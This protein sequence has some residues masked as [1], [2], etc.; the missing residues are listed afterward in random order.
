MIT[1]N[2]LATGA[3]GM[4]T[5]F[6]NPQQGTEVLIIDYLIDW[7]SNNSPFDPPDPA[8]EQRITVLGTPP[9]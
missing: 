7:I 9:P 4:S 8:I 6:A 3:L 2:C 1:T 5:L